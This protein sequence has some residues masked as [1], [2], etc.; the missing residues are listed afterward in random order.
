MGV[1]EDQPISIFPGNSSTLKGMFYLLHYLNNEYGSRY[2]IKADPKV[3]RGST[4]KYIDKVNESA[5]NYWANDGSTNLT[6]SFDSPFFVTNYAIMNASPNN[7][8][9]FPKSWKLFGV[10]ERGNLHLIDK[11]ENQD[12]GKGK[13][14]V[15][16]TFSTHSRK[17]YSTFIFNQTMSSHGDEC[18]Y[19]HLKHFEFFGVICGKTGYCDLSRFIRT[20]RIINHSFSFLHSFIIILLIS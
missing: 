10:D 2:S 4:D 11:R 19:I 7:G 6:F 1:F 18:K 3:S 14:E 5:T 9:S 15:V 20:C 13:E 17:A 8:N 12:F 16:K